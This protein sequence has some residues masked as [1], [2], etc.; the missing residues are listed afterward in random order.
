MADKSQQT[1]KP[2]PQKL[3]KARKEGQFPVSKEFVAGVQFLAFVILLGNYGG[4]WLSNLVATSRLVLARGFHAELTPVMV[5]ELLYLMARRLAYPMATGAGILVLTSVSAHLAVTRLGFS[6]NKLAPDLSRLNPAKNLKNIKRQNMTNFVQALILI[7]LF[8]MAVY[9][10]AKDN[11]PIFLQL[12]FQTVDSGLKRV[13]SSIGDLLWKGAYV[14]MIWGTIDLFRQQSRFAQEMRMSKQEIRDEGKESDG[15][16][17]VKARIRRLQKEALRRRMMSHVPTATAVIV[18]PTHFAVAIRYHVE[19]MATPVV[20][21]KGKNF[22]ALRIRQ[23]AIENMVPIVENPPL[24]QA[25]YKS[26]EIG[27]EIPASF[28][29]AIAEILA[30][31]Y[32]LRGRK[33]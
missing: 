2:T 33:V 21:A 26:V 11:L 24:A 16:P 9:A 20:V 32:K 4:E 6:F 18:N 13:T 3:E 29:R 23:I 7:P 27:Q 8:S 17:Q 12:P 14:F 15:N 10:V 5:R 30:Y 22:L 28:Y 25:L 1:E 31:I 19:S